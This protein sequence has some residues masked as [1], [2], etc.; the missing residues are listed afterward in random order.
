[1][2]RFMGCQVP[3]YVLPCLCGSIL[4]FKA[5]HNEIDTFIEVFLELET[6]SKAYKHAQHYE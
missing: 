6:V 2:E 5:N 1:M 4:T 3:E